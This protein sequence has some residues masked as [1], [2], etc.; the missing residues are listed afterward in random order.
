MHIELSTTLFLLEVPLLAFLYVSIFLFA[1]ALALFTVYSGEAVP[2]AS[3]SLIAPTRMDSGLHVS[4]DLFA[5]SRFVLTMENAD[6]S[7]TVATPL[8]KWEGITL[9]NDPSKGLHVGT[10]DWSHSAL[11]G[12]LELHALPAL[13][14]RVCLGHNRLI[15]TPA[16]DRLPD[17]LQYLD[18]SHNL[19]S[20]YLSITK[21]PDAL[22][23]IDMTHNC[24]NGR[25]QSDCLFSNG[26]VF[27]YDD[28]F[29]VF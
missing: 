27:Q 3:P 22:L 20:G 2:P 4:A 1:A 18:I 6:P 5:L 15:G 12:L 25:I 7:W 13:V 19:L 11:G 16:L 29:T 24:L 21:L 14:E 26:R 17:S 8:D 28:R 9:R 10:I 23:H